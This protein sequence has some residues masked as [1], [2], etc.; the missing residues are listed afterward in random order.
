MICDIKIFMKNKIFLIFCI[1]LICTAK[2]QFYQL[3]AE[4]KAAPVLCGMLLDSDSTT[5]I[6]GCYI[7][8]HNLKNSDE[9]EKV[10]VR[11]ALHYKTDL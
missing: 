11:W 3:S 5:L 1:G 9:S 10:I 4:Y 2:G 7:Y 6:P 8:S